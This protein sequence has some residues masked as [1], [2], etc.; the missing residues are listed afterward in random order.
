MNTN[1]FITYLQSKIV[2]ASNVAIEVGVQ[3]DTITTTSYN[4]LHNNNNITNYQ[5]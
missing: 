4:L 2:S 5:R 1:L 3:I